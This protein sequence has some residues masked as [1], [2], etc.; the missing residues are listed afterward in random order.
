M[1]LREVDGPAGAP[2]ERPLHGTLDRLVV[3]SDA[4]GRQPARRPG[5]PPAVGLP[6]AGRR[7]RPPA[8]AA[9][10]LRDPGLH[11][12]ARHVG[13]PR[14]RSSRRCS[15]AS[16]RCSPPATARTRSSCS[17]TPGRPTAARSSSTRPRTGPLPGLPVRR[18]RRRSSTSATRRVAEPRPPRADRQVVAAATA[19]WSCRCC[20]PTSS[21]RSPRTPATRCSRPATCPS[22]RSVARAAAR[23]VRRLLRRRSS[24][25]L[26]A[27]DHFDV[28]SWLEPLEVY[29]YAAAY[30]PDPAQPGQGAAAVRRR[31]RPPDR[32]RVGAVA[33]QGPGADGAAPRRRAALDAAH[34]P[35]RRHA[36]TSTSS[37]SARRRSRAE[38]DKLG[39]DAHARAVRRQARAAHVPLP[40]RDPG[41]RA[42]AHA[43]S[44]AAPSRAHA[45]TAGHG[46]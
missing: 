17:S 42:R 22:S 33:G 11:R 26:A 38:L 45:S 28:T 4:A 39:V 34:L 2:W 29:G 20:A 9:E 21:A 25:A 44:G 36:A 8:A 3:E 46:P 35:R 15:S 5:A 43:V 27:A 31:D 19:R 40:G 24:S 23:R 30:S 41:A 6:P 16:T 1:S 18:G 37:T 12:P 7:A 14:R 32:R 13:E 10:R